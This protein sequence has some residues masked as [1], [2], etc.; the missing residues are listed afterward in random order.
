MIDIKDI[1]YWADIE[2][3]YGEESDEFGNMKGGFVYV[4]VKSFD[5]RTALDQIL[6]SLKDEKL[7][8][9]H[10]NF[11]QPYE[12]EM[13]WETEEQTKHFFELYN[14]ARGTSDVIFDTLYAYENIE[15]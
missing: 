7:I 15:D 13:E 14:D 10:I 5:V 3:T 2:Y 9:F 1:V 11:V 4:F 12:K 6:N 8:P